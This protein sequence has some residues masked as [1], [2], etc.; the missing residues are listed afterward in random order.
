[1]KLSATA[2]VPAI[3][4]AARIAT[5]TTVATLAVTPRLP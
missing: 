1:M 2:P 4:L 3:A 5:T